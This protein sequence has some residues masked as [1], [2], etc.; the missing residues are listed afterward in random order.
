MSFRLDHSFYR[1]E[2]I[3]MSRYYIRERM[4]KRQQLALSNVV[5][6]INDTEAVKA[7]AETIVN[8]GGRFGTILTVDQIDGELRWHVSV[9][10]LVDGFKPIFWEKLKPSLR[11]G[12]RQLAR[13]LLEDI[14]QPGS[15]FEVA[16]SF[17]LGDRVRWSKAFSSD[18][19]NAE[20]TIVRIVPIR[21][22]PEF[23]LYDIRFKFGMHTLLASQI[24]PAQ[25]SVVS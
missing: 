16:Q 8:D 23:T 9:S 20:G 1:P 3:F 2:L 25:L 21:A 15:D 18:Y 24:E 17:T 7:F 4:T 12:V 6:D 19:K 14:G 10:A 22:M 11:E 5:K 13:E